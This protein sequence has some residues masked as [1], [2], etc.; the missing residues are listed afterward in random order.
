M[1]QIASCEGGQD[2]WLLDI[3]EGLTA[4]GITAETCECVARECP[5]GLND[6]EP[7]LVIA[8]VHRCCVFWAPPVVYIVTTE[9]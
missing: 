7:M 2:M 5:E 1:S 4:K 6:G 3:E 8:S 9:A